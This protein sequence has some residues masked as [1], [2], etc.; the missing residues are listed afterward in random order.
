M[1]TAE[2]AVAYVEVSKE[3]KATQAILALPAL[4]RPDTP[5]ST[6]SPRIAANAPTTMRSRNSLNGIVQNRA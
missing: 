5:C 6:R 4:N 2:E 1:V 3:K